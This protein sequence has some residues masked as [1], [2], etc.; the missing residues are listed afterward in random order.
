MGY[1]DEATHERI[2]FDI[3]TVPLGEAALYLEPVEPPSNYRDPVKIEEFIRTKEREQLE[4]AALDVDLCRVVA[5]GSMLP[6]SDQPTVQLALD[7]KDERE[8][9]E[10]FFTL[11][12][13]C[14]F[15]GFN[16]L[17]FDLPILLRRALYLNVEAPYIA[18]DRYRHPRVQDVLQ[19]LTWNG[20]LKYRSQA[21]YCK[22]FGLPVEDDDV[23]GAEIPLLVATGRID[24]LVHHVRCDVLQVRALAQRL[25]HWPNGASRLYRGK[26]E[27]P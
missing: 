5:I 4:R 26:V 18:L 8:M 25:G 10:L 14:L 20:K 7:E 6:D 2:L 24:A 3:E 19:I 11:A 23:Q 22:R 15:I 13:A 16:I 21:F 9:L 1:N 27:R 12:E 17:D